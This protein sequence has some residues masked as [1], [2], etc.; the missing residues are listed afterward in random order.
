MLAFVPN[1][2]DVAWTLFVFIIVPIGWIAGLI[3]FRSR[4]KRALWTVLIAAFY[5]AWIFVLRAGEYA[6]KVQFLDDDRHPI[7]GLTVSYFTHPQSDRIGRFARALNGEITTNSEGEIILHP[8]HAHGVSLT[9]RDP[10]FQTAGFRIE[11][12]GK[13]YGHQMGPSDSL[14]F[15]EPPE[16]PPTTGAFQGTWVFDARTEH[17]IVVALK[18]K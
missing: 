11:A 13:R 1:L 3:Y 9:V 6:L 8:N 2:Q 12:A 10:R 18:P 15:I 4:L 16:P 17:R 14:T 5:T 7:A